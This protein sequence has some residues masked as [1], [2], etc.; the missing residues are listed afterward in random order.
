MRKGLAGLCGLCITGG[1]LAWIPAPHANARVGVIDKELLGVRLLQSYKRVL[2]LYG[3]PTRIYRNGEVVN[4][5]PATDASGKETGGVKGLGE[6]DSNGGAPGGGKQGGGPPGSG[7]PGGSGGFGSPSTAVPGQSSA[8]A[9]GYPGSGGPGAPG[10]NGPGSGGFPGSGGPLGGASSTNEKPPTFAESGGFIWVYFY[11]RDELAYEFVFNNDE[12][13]VAVWERGRYKGLP[14][15]RGIR[16]GDPASKVYST[17]GWPDTIEQQA[18]NLALNYNI[19]H[20]AQISLL[21]GKVSGI[22]VFLRESQI[23]RVINLASGGG[24]AGGGGGAS[25]TPN[26]A[27][28]RPGGGGGGG[29]RSG[30][31]SAD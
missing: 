21:N 25:R 7:G 14:S 23:P 4:F 15:E 13:C 10:S 2:Q 19:R 12:R 20:H 29:G 22:A 3:Q 31:S 6:E 8:G 26:T 11:P 16:L 24:A 18:S 5:I 17:Y 27:G 30:T 1:L 28:K 9:P